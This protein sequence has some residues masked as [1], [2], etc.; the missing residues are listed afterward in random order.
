MFF[1][2]SCVRCDTDGRGRSM[3]WIALG[4]VCT[5]VGVA[6]YTARTS[7]ARRNERLE[8]AFFRARGQRLKSSGVRSTRV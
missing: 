1:C 6:A 7:S 3:E 4:C 2:V 5:V 8:T